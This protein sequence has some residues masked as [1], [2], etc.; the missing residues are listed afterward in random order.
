MKAVHKLDKDGNRSIF[1]SD[2][3]KFEGKI[4]PELEFNYHI[5]HSLDRGRDEPGIMFIR[6]FDAGS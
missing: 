3:E 2:N 1:F 4:P 5:L 6:A